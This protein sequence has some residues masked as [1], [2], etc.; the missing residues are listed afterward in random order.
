MSVRHFRKVLQKK[1]KKSKNQSLKFQSPYNC[2][3]LL[4]TK[5]YIHS[6]FFLPLGISYVS[7]KLAYSKTPGNSHLYEVTLKK[8]L[9]YKLSI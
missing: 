4:N 8:C 7:P 2:M 3:N 6:Y 9:V 5:A 1:K